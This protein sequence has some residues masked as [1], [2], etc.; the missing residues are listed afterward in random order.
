VNDD[1]QAAADRAA[2]AWVGKQMFDEWQLIRNPPPL[3]P[4]VDQ[5]RYIGDELRKIIDN[6]PPLVTIIGKPAIHPETGEPLPDAA[7]KVAALKLLLRVTEEMRRLPV[8]PLPA[9]TEE[10]NAAVEKVRAEVVEAE[11]QAEALRQGDGESPDET[12]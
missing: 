12:P 3:P 2:L 1:D 8:F 9:T 11:R 10:I 4:P 5:L 7:L 6:P